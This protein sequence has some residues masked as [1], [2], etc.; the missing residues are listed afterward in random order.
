MSSTLQETVCVLASIVAYAFHKLG[1]TIRTL[2]S[3]SPV[4]YPLQSGIHQLMVLYSL[5]SS[6]RAPFLLP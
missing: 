2:F 4:R 6:L 5:S 1:R 3:H